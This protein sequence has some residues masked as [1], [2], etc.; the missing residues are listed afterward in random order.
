MDTD[1]FDQQTT[2]ETQYFYVH[3]AK[4]TLHISPTT[5]L[6]TIQKSPYLT[7]SI[8]RIG[9]CNKKYTDFKGHIYSPL[10]VTIP[11]KD[12]R[13]H[14]A[15][16]D[17]VKNTIHV[18]SKYPIKQIER[19]LTD[20]QK[21]NL[22]ILVDHTDY[23]YVEVCCRHPFENSG[24]VVEALD[25]LRKRFYVQK[26]KKDT[27]ELGKGEEYSHLFKNLYLDGYFNI[28]TYKLVDRFKSANPILSG[29]IEP[30][31]EIQLY[32]P[33]SLE[34]AQMR[35]VSVLKAIVSF[36]GIQTIPMDKT[37]EQDDYSLILE[38]TRFSQNKKV[39]YWLKQPTLKT[40]PD[41]PEHIIRHLQARKLV[42]AIWFEAKRSN[43]ICSYLS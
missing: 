39:L 7:G 19:F 2:P 18:D 33:Q 23:T 25:T 12:K 21:S 20:L 5:P 13:R 24:K 6:T 4:A 38:S 17:Y 27:K 8:F 42:N 36:L 30:K 29:T 28:K 3:R 26:T 15:Y 22:G 9:W 10:E 1:N 43:E 40:L 34:E 35:G 31:L 32:K 11:W 16:I 37:F 14:W 41:L